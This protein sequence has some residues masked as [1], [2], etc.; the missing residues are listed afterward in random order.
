M[1]NKKFSQ[2]TLVTDPADVDFLAGY[3][4]TD[5]V[6]IAPSNLGTGEA[7]TGSN[8]G[9]G[10]EVFKQKTGVD[11]EFRTLFAG[12]N[13]TLTQNANDITIASSGGGGGADTFVY[14]F[15]AN[16]SSNTATSYYSFRNKSNS[17]MTS[18]TQTATAIGGLYYVHFSVPV[19]CFLKEVMIRNIQ[20][21]GTCT[22]SRMKIFKNFNVLE[23]TGSYIS[24]ANSTTNNATWT[25]SLTS[26]DTSFTAGDM[27]VVGFQQNGTMGGVHASYQF[28]T[29]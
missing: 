25:E 8:V 3:D 6:R 22:Q 28:E 2:F 4:G 1:A 14:Q 29:L 23:Y 16:H 21:A 9:L 20:T 12:T 24:W 26:A 10:S 11:L 5:N 18:F 17:T 27:I 13:I 15:S 7:N 19:D